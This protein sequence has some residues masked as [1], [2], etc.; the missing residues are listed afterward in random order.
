MTLT[1]LVVFIGIALIVRLLGRKSVANWLILLAS[2]L[3]VYWLQP[4]SSIRSLEYWLP[5]ILVMICLL[6][7]LLI[8]PKEK[9]RTKDNNIA[10]CI[11]LATIVVISLMRYIAPGL[12][13]GIINPPAV[14]NVAILLIIVVILGLLIR[15]GK[16]QPYSKKLIGSVGILLLIGIFAILK[17]KPFTEQTSVLLRE[18]NRQTVSLA[19][20]REIAW[21][22]Y[23][24]F[25]FRLI[26]V[27]R[28]WQQG[29]VFTSDLQLFLIYIL[30]FPAFTAGPIERLDRFERNFNKL[31]DREIKDDLLNGGAR[32]T[33][34]LFYK[35]ILADSLSL[36]AF[37]AVSI[38]A[39]QSRFWMLVIV[40]SY[41]LRLYFDFS[42]YTDLAVGI[43]RI[44]GIKLPENFDHPYRSTNLTLFWNRWH[45]TLTQW[46]RTYYFN[47]ITR[48]LRTRKARIPAAFIIFF[49]QISTMVLIGLWHGISLNFVIWGLW[50]GIGMFIQNRWSEWRKTHSGGEDKTIFVLIMEK[51]LSILLTFNY[52]ALGWIWFALPNMQ[53]S[54]LVFYKLFGDM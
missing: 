11:A 27:L 22:G 47:P 25:A 2:L 26:H 39:V 14:I 17:Y 28:E 4:V 46:F 37:D 49:T 5:S 1:H 41:A 48:Y 9:I 24:Y 40:Y 31:E 6:T 34:G 15:I 30:F 42:G 3:T 12:L 13:T 38:Q 32:I 45:I 29:R 23:S 35:F 8:T 18:W 54:I 43:A 51:A 52:I 10:A 21:V 53:D 16:D 7:W 33:K 44:M 50:N 20:A 19:N 36:V